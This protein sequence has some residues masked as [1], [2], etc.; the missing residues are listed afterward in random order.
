MVTIKH[1]NIWNG[2]EMNRIISNNILIDS[3]AFVSIL[4]FEIQTFYNL[5]I[6]DFI[7]HSALI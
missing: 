5:N 7:S 2:M 3:E 4:N 6:F 1:W